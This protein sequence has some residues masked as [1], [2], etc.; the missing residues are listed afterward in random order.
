[1]NRKSFFAA[2]ILS[3]IA[4]AA[5]EPSA[6]GVTARQN[7]PWNG[8]VDIL[9]T[10]SSDTPCDVDVKAT[11]NGQSEPV[12][13]T[14]VSGDLFNVESGDRRIV[15]DPVAEGVSLPLTG[16]KATVEPVSADSKKY[17]LLNLF[18]G[19]VSYS[20]TEPDWK[21]EPMAYLATN[22]VFR[23]IGA[24]TFN[25]GY[26]QPQVI[27]GFI[28]NRSLA[29]KATL[30]SDYYIAIFPLTTAQGYMITKKTVEEEDCTTPYSVAYSTLRGSKAG[31]GVC[32][33][34]TFHKVAEES[35]LD[36][37][38]KIPGLSLPAGWVV[39]LPTAAQWENAARAG[40]DAQ[41][42]LCW[43]EGSEFDVSFSDMTNIVKNAGQWVPGATLTAKI[44]TFP[45][46]PW[47]LYD[48]IGCVYEYVLDWRMPKGPCLT[49]DVTDPTGIATGENTQDRQVRG[50]RGNGSCPL[51]ACLPGNSSSGYSED[52]ARSARLCIHLKPVTKLAE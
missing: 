33:P 1:M 45:A 32:W 29:R 23:R 6:T 40:T 26:P 11:W 15:W 28:N 27:A 35:L 19:S 24:T 8:N 49:T 25:F 36:K 3:A 30:S 2:A 21:G 51:E 4:C 5:A 48:T 7:W 34:E 38:R 52:T 13:L 12:S 9:Y 22:I 47:G 41:D 14:R 20:A 39:D 42:R 18:D 31:D 10:L 46:N 44:G 17:L 50:G 43:V 16:F 37:I